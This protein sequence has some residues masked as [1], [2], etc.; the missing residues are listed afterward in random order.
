MFLWSSVL[1][2][3]FL[4]KFYEVFEGLRSVLCSFSSLLLRD[5]GVDKEALEDCVRGH[6]EDTDEDCSNR[7]G[8]KEDN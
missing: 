8:D 1:V 4:R 3:A 6:G 2:A 7:V 5:V